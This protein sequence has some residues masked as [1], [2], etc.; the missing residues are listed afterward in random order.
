MSKTKEEHIHHWLKSAENDFDTA[1]YL[2]AGKRY[3][4]ALFFCHLTIEKISKAIW[5]KNNEANIPPK[6]HN[7]LALLQLS[8][9]EMPNNFIEL[10]V[11][12]N[13]FQ[14]E[15][16]YPSEIVELTSATE[17]GVAQFFFYETKYLKEW[18]LKKLQ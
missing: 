8:K 14:I 16:R 17:N 12:L 4:Y 2:L 3:V 15:G 10:I 18:L 7:L 13:K 9:T 6:M 11:N 1:S 5:I